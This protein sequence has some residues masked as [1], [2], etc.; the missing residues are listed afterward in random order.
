MRWTE[1]FQRSDETRQRYFGIVQRYRGYIQQ[2][3]RG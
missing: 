3:K 1:E 2:R